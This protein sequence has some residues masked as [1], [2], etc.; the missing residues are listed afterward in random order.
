MARRIHRRE[1]LLRDATALTPRLSLRTTLGSREV[2]VFAGFRGDAL[3]IYFDEDPVL[4]FN[5][6][7]ELRRAFVDG[8]MYRADL[9]RLMAL[10]RNA[11]ARGVELL[12]EALDEKR[13]DALL[14]LAAAQL[15]ALHE[16]VRAGGY[17]LVGEAPPG[18][19]AVDR[20]AAWLDAAGPLRVAA[21][22]RVG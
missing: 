4:Q 18:G 10:R 15:A 17:A 11:D 9:G 21:G 7:Q 2:A 5:A 13:H 1:D 8:Q 19:G 20:L 16:A 6:K 12:A 14:A 22:P 3:S